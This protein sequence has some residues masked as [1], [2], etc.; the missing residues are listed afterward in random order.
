MANGMGT[1]DVELTGIKNDIADL[2]GEY[3]NVKVTITT[4]DRSDDFGMLDFSKKNVRTLLDIG[5]HASF[6]RLSI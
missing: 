6:K 5:L 2:S 3:K 1:R 4:F